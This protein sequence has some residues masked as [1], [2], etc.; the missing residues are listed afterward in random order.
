LQ[1]IDREFPAAA[2]AETLCAERD[3]DSQVPLE[4]SLDRAGDADPV[5][6]NHGGNTANGGDG[7]LR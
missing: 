1:R 2:A 5:I 6:G 4:L 7:A 3:L